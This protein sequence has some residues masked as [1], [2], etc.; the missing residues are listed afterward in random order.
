MASG[1]PPTANCSFRN[2]VHKYVLELVRLYAPTPARKSHNSRIIH[3]HP[4]A[5]YPGLLLRSPC[6]TVCCLSEGGPPMPVADGHRSLAATA[7]VWESMEG[8]CSIVDGEQGSEIV[9]WK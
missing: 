4:L 6:L 2:L 7:R 1:F 3:I 5:P 9:I 8:A